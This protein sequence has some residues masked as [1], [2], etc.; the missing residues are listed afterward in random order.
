VRRALGEVGEDG[1]RLREAE[2]FIELEDGAS[3]VRVL[4]E[5]LGPAPGVSDS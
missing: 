5:K 1:A 3:H 2:A 4:R